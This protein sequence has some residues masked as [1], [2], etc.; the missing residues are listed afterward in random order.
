MMMMSNDD[1]GLI[2]AAKGA[3]FI[4]YEL[5]SDLTVKSTL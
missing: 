2:I 1:T 5:M 3:F 4:L